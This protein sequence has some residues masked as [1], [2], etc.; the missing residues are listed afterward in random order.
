[1]PLPDAQTDAFSQPDQPLFMLSAVLLFSQALSEGSFPP[2]LP[3]FLSNLLIICLLLLYNAYINA[4][5]DLQATCLLFYC[6]SIL[7]LFCLTC[8]LILFFNFHGSKYIQF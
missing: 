1:C 2:F 5:S 7:F 3:S 8:C 6:Y 4:P